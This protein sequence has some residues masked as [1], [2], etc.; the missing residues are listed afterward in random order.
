MYHYCHD[1]HFMLVLASLVFHVGLLG[2]QTSLYQDTFQQKKK[3]KVYI[4]N[5]S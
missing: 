1:C 5:K 2:L 4:K 3:K